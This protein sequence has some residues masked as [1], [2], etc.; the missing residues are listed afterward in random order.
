M[1]SDVHHAALKA[2]AKVAFSVALLNGCSG[3]DAL[4]GAESAD[5]DEALSNEAAIAA[6]STK[7]PAQKSGTKKPAAA[8]PC[9]DAG[10]E[11]DAAPAKPSCEALLAATFPIPADYK[12]EPEPQS[13]DVVACCD[14][15][16]TTKDAMSTYR[17]DCCVAYDPTATPDPNVGSGMNEHAMACTPWGP[18]VPPSMKRARRSS[19][20]TMQAVA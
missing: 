3:V 10:T 14:E 5:G 6:S 17:W 9:P 12:W 15:E 2:A 7:K 19:V 18:P 16:L 11:A 4:R 1:R 20:A 13:K 8:E